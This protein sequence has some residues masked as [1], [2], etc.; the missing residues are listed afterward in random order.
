MATKILYGF[1]DLGRKIAVG[2]YNTSVT[3]TLLS[4]DDNW[5][6][7]LTGGGQYEIGNSCTISGPNGHIYVA[8]WKDEND[9]IISYDNPYTFTVTESKTIYAH[10]VAGGAEK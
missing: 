8:Y 6:E 10:I 5:Q 9:N 4:D 1:D 3:V 2:S 7:D